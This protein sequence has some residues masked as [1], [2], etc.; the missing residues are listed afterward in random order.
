MCL[1]IIIYTS[2]S[3]VLARDIALARGLIYDQTHLW[4]K[5]QQKSLHMIINY[6][7][8]IFTV[9]ATGLSVVKIYNL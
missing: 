5:P 8:R 4:Y 3:I 2:S 1:M 6:E 9:Q 7:Y